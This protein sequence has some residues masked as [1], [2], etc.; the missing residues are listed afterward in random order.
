VV[1][2]WFLDEPLVKMAAEL[3]ALQVFSNS[4]NNVAHTD[5][6][7][8]LR[9]S[10][11]TLTAKI[12]DCISLKEKLALAIM[13]DNATD[14]LLLAAKY[15]EFNEILECL[16]SWE[17]LNACQNLYSGSEVFNAITE[18]IT[19]KVSNIQ[20]KLTKFKNIKKM[21]LEKNWIRCM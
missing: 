20:R 14:E 11:N 4:I 3:A 7:N 15:T 21:Q 12:L 9:L 10:I 6:V 16:P 5:T 13:E 8:N 19:E 17:Q 1:T 2:N 18:R